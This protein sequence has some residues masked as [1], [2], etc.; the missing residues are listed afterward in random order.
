RELLLAT[1]HDAE[2][3]DQPEQEKPEIRPAEGE[4]SNEHDDQGDETHP[5]PDAGQERDDAPHQHSYGDARRLLA[6]G[7]VTARAVDEHTYSAGERARA[8]HSEDDRD[9]RQR[10]PTLFGRDRRRRRALRHRASHTGGAGTRP[11][12]SSSE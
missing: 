2:D 12:A 4:G 3:H 11:R 9:P 10:R 1:A 5:T 6:A 8:Q 7:H